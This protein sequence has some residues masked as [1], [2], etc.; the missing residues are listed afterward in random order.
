LGWKIGK[1]KQGAFEMVHKW[2]VLLM[3]SLD[4]CGV[5]PTRNIKEIVPIAKRLLGLGL[6]TEEELDL[7]VD[8]TERRINRPKENQKA[9]YSGKKTSCCKKNTIISTICCVVLFLG[10]THKGSVH[11]FS[12]LKTDCPKEQVVD[13]ELFIN[14][15]LWA[16]LGYQGI[17]KLYEIYRLK[18][19]TNVLKK[20]KIILSLNLQKSKKNITLM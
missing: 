6:I 19:L 9:F 14:S 10:T 18:Y 15:I 13:N 20:R 5:L 4:K 3:K 2:F 7:I 12:M 8:V 1:T 11:D 17:V 16:D